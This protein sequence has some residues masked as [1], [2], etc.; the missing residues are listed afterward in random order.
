M[1]YL[2]KMAR[3]VPYIVAVALAGATAPAPAQ[4]NTPAPAPV[5]KPSASSPGVSGQQ[6]MTRPISGTGAGNAKGAVIAT[7][8][9]QTPAFVPQRLTVRYLVDAAFPVT[10]MADGMTFDCAA[11]KNSPTPVMA[12]TAQANGR[13]VDLRAFY[14]K[15]SPI[16]PIAPRVSGKQ[17]NGACAGTSGD[18]CRIAMIGPQTVG[19]DFYAKP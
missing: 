3:S 5:A 10:L 16:A 13:Y 17:W 1:T 15:T 2:S 7:G 12:C 9:Q 14:G 4:E 11:E 18:T 6:P 19:I 8:V